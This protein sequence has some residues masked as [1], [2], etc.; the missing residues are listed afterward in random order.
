MN[1]NIILTI[2][3]FVASVLVE[4]V[5][6]AMVFQWIANK[7]Q[8]KQQQNLKHEMDNIEKQNKFDFEQLQSEIRMCKAEIISQVKE[9]DKNREK[10]AHQQ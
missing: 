6:L 10:D 7:S 8:E 1:Q 9:N 5:I 3:E 4:G 2:A